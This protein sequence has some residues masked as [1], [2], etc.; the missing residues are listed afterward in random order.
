MP[1]AD[2]AKIF[3]VEL[4]KNIPGNTY[5]SDLSTVTVKGKKVLWRQVGNNKNNS[6]VIVYGYIVSQPF[7]KRINGK[8]IPHINVSK[9]PEEEHDKVSAA[10]KLVGVGPVNFW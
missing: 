5:S 8:D 9:I 6:Y 1:K 3:T 4:S 10:L 2:T 7:L